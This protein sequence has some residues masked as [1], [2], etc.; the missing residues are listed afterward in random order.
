MD[1]DFLGPLIRKERREGLQEGLQKGEIKILSNQLGKRFG[2]LP[3]WVEDRLINL[4]TSELEDLSL[5][6]FDV[7]TLDELFVR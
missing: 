1:H 2:E 6:V 7:K 4:S 5:R 3:A